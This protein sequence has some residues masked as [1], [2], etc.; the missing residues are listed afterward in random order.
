MAVSYRCSMC[1]P[2]G[3]SLGFADLVAG[4]PTHCHGR[5]DTTRPGIMGGFR[6]SCECNRKAQE[7]HDG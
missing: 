1:L 2:E 3:A 5:G 6:C 7:A 4:P